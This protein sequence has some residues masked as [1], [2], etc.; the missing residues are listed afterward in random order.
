MLTVVILYA[1]FEYMIR[2]QMAKESEP[3]TLPGRR[4][5]MRPTGTSVLGMFGGLIMVLICLDERITRKVPCINGQ[6]E[7]NLKF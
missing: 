4:K 5:S 6:H 3:L 2:A 7:R 1:T